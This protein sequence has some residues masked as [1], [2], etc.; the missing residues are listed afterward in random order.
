MKSDRLLRWVALLLAVAA[1][2]W[3][4]DT[5]LSESRRRARLA[6]KTEDIRALDRLAES[7][8]PDRAWLNALKATGTRTPPP[9]DYLAAGHFP[10]GCATAFPRSADPVVEGWQRRETLL[11]LSRV[12]FSAIPAF[13][14]KASHQR[15]PWR[16]LEAKFLFSAEPGRGDAQLLFVALERMPQPGRAEPVSAHAQT[17]KP[18]VPAANPVQEAR[19]EDLPHRTEGSGVAEPEVPLEERYRLV[20]VFKMLSGGGECAILDDLKWNRQLL[21][22]SGEEKEGLKM[23]EVGL[24]YAVVN[25]GP[26]RE[27]LGI[28]VD[29][30]GGGGSSG[31]AAS[32][33]I[34]TNRFGSRIG[35]TR[36]EFSRDA[37]MEYYQEMMDHPER[38]VGLFNALEPDYGED[39]NIKGYRLNTERGEC[40]F[41]DEV[42]LKQGDVIRR[43]NALSMTSQRRAEFFI[44]E[45]VRGRLGNVVLDIDRKGKPEKLVYLIK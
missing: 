24:D 37:V 28:S 27:R 36:W 35:E 29:P 4:L 14:L 41:F 13:C 11:N 16:L 15:P 21:L 31:G 44:G 5:A 42:G 7:R 17:P 1:I 30:S 45:F 26:R 12:D 33:V 43:L 32:A 10:D 39:G 40:E 6:H 18:V 20:G 23:E 38:L 19:P 3:T 8:A 22:C 34:S 25:D 9:L 2:A